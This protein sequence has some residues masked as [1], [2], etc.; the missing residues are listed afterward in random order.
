MAELRHILRALCHQ[1]RMRP[2]PADPTLR[3][4]LIQRIGHLPSPED[5]SRMAEADL[6]QW[7]GVIDRLVFDLDRADD[8]RRSDRA[9]QY[10]QRTNLPPRRAPLANWYERALRK[11]SA[12]SKQAPDLL[13]P[14]E[15]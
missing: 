7:R 8:H 14:L 12:M 10:Q 13:E 2:V 11:Q 5:F 9:I 6:P 15:H 4:D 1:L 3:A